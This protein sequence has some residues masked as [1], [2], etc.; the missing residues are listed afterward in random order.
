MPGSAGSSL[1]D[2]SGV[3]AVNCD[4]KWVKDQISAAKLGMDT[5]K[6]KI[7]TSAWPLFTSAGQPGDHLVDLSSPGVL[8]V[9]SDLAAR[10]HSDEDIGTSRAFSSTLDPRPFHQV[11]HKQLRNILVNTGL[12][13]NVIPLDSRWVGQLGLDVGIVVQDH[14]LSSKST[15]LAIEDFVREALLLCQVARPD[16]RSLGEVDSLVFARWNKPA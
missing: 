7:V 11:G 12:A 15:Y 16:I 3:T 14:H 5:K 6:V 2:L 13:V 10:V 4:P 1:L 8:K 9:F